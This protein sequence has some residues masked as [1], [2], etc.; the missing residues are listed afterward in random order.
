[1]AMFTK[2][3]TGGWQRL[4]ALTLLVTLV[5]LTFAFV[6]SASGDN[7]K[8]QAQVT[9]PA[10]TAAAPGTEGAAD[11]APSEIP[12]STTQPED[13]EGSGTSAT[14]DPELPSS[15]SEDPE[16]PPVSAV[17]DPELPSSSNEDPEGPPQSGVEDP[18]AGP[19][20]SEGTPPA[21]DTN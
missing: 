2:H 1:M 14:E 7:N 12:G 13:P 6:V 5:F 19:A 20:A 18:E 17:E 8:F 4:L 11:P 15:T 10:A 16:G 9:E 3:M 21:G